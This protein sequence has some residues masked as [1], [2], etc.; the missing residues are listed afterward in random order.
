MIRG[1]VIFAVVAIMGQHLRFV[2]V[3][4]ARHR[5]VQGIAGCGTKDKS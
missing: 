1:D 2:R 3:S 4:R 5:S